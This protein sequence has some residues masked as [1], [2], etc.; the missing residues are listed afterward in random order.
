M[1]AFA[2]I[3]DFSSSG[4][5]ET[6]RRI[7]VESLERELRLR[8][9]RL[10]HAQLGVTVGAD[11]ATIRKAFTR[12]KRQFN[13]Q[14]YTVH[15]E[16]AVS[17]AGEIAGLVEAAF[18]HLRSPSV[19]DDRPL[20]SLQP[21]RRDET[22]RALETLRAGI[23]RRK[24]EALRLKADG[25]IAEARR[26]FEAVRALDPHDETA[27]TQLRLLSTKPEKRPVRVWL[28]VVAWLSALLS[29]VVERVQS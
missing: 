8:R 15:G 3:T 12:L 5:D 25:R 13:P 17:I 10:P 7:V 18:L 1:T 11:A 19:H 6:V 26:M 2:P 22:L 24:A 9:D 27:R 4:S 14:T 23:A 16:Q 28:A 29:R 21:Q 20:P